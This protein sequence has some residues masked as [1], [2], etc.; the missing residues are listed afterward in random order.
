MSGASRF[1]YAGAGVGVT[2]SS[3]STAYVGYSFGNSG[4]GNNGV[5]VYVGYSF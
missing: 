2:L 4:A 1:G 5:G 3:R